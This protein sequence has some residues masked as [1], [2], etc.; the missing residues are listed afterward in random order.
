V[1]ERDAR[2][3]DAAAAAIR[4]CSGNDAPDI[5][6]IINA[7]AVAYRGAIPAD[8]WREPYMSLDELCAEIDAGVRFTGCI[9]SG[10]LVGVMGIQR[11][12]NVRLIR[13]AYVRPDWQGH[14]IGSQLIRHLG[15]SNDLPV[16]IGTWA[17][18]SWAVRFY[19]GH[20]F[21]LVP[22]EAIAPLLQTYWNVPERQI[23]TSVVLASPALSAQDA[24][25]L[26]A[27]A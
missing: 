20:G 9:A 13:H 17:A 25:R 7:A 21:A 23:E 24:S 11:V 6:H 27:A 19:E 18:A 4:P 3:T 15:A 22:A 2:T 16:L 5:L 14:G 26:I 10:A 1:A 8:R 12:R